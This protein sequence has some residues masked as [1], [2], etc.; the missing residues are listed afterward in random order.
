MSGADQLQGVQQQI[1]GVAQK[2][3][4]FEASLIAAEQAGD[5]DKVSFLRSRLLELGEEKTLLLRAQPGGEHRSLLPTCFSPRAA[6]S[7]SP[8][9]PP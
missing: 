5:A 2:V 9:M 8:R 3:A 6:L 4:D 7:P 1:T